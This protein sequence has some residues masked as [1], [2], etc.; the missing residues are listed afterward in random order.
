[1]KQ[2][3]LFGKR[4][5]KC[6]QKAA[7]LLLTGVLALGMTACGGKE[8]SGSEVSSAA[9]VSSSSAVTSASSAAQSNQPVSSAAVSSETAASSAVTA[10]KAASPKAAKSKT[11]VKAGAADFSDAAMVGNS[12]VEGLNMQ[13]LLPKMDFYSSVGLTVNTVFTKP[14]RGSSVPI[15]QALAQKQYKR[16]YFQFGENELGWNGTQPFYSAYAKV[17][18]AVQKEQPGAK[19]YIQSILPVSAAVS[20]KN[21]E[22]TNNQRIN[23]YNAVLQ[24]LAKAKNAVYLDVASALKDESGCL[25]DEAAE[26]GV[27]LNQ[28]YCKVWVQYL[29][30]H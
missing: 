30:D 16:I 13:G 12:C 14:M 26:D 7:V 25:P 29:S 23:E 10:H 6:C 4:K 24:K 3:S 17:L 18:D 9:E 22:D 21:E 28:K 20:E 11:A 8:V 2:G 15:M 1:M 27:H 5:H 19:L